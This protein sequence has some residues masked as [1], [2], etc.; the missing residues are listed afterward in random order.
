MQFL[1]AHCRQVQLLDSH[2]I[3]PGRNGSF[4]PVEQNG[5]ALIY[6]LYVLNLC[7]LVWL[8]LAR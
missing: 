2:A 5:G 6:Y 4:T 7:L 8:A 3:L 1:L